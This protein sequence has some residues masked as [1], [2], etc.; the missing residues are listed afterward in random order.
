MCDPTDKCHR[1]AAATLSAR[2]RSRHRQ[3]HRLEE[4]GRGWRRRALERRDYLNHD[5]RCGDEGCKRNGRGRE[6]RHRRDRKKDPGFQGLERKDSEHSTMCGWTGTSARAGPGP[7]ATS[8]TV[9]SRLKSHVCLRFFPEWPV[10]PPTDPLEGWIIAA[11][12]PTGLGSGN[13]EPA[14]VSSR[15]P[16]TAADTNSKKRPAPVVLRLNFWARVQKNDG[17]LGPI[18]STESASLLGDIEDQRNFADPHQEVPERIGRSKEPRPCTLTPLAGSS[19]KTGSLRDISSSSRNKIKRPVIERRSVPHLEWSSRRRFTPASSTC[20][21]C[22]PEWVATLP[23]PE[24]VIMMRWTRAGIATA[25]MGLLLCAGWA[26]KSRADD[27]APSSRTPALPTAKGAIEPPAPALPAD[28]VAAMQEARYDDARRA[29]IALGDQ[30]T[31]ADDRAYFA[32]LLRSRRTAGREIASGARESCN[33]RSGTAPAGR[34]AAKIRFELAGAELAAGNLA[35]AEEIA[36]AEAGAPAVRRP[37]G[38]AGRG[39]SCL[40]GPAARAR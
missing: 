37:E 27:G 31:D 17:A 8:I 6:A 39:V 21:P 28:I 29:L 18:T 25:L 12:D 16:A 15:N 10:S 23:S 9:V 13:R 40:R 34:W 35:A 7:G 20:G 3:G 5:R 36:R 11:P 2:R 24:S 30:A 14:I 19:T 1:R 4:V 32:Y 38:P 22:L 33:P 26:A